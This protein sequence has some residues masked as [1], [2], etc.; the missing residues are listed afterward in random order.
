MGQFRFID[1]NHDQFIVPCILGHD[2]MQGTVA[3]PAKHQS[4]GAGHF[5]GI[6]LDH[7]TRLQNLSHVLFGD[8]S[9]EHALDGVNAEDDLAGIHAGI[10][11][12]PSMPS[13]NS[14]SILVLEDAF[15][16]NSVRRKI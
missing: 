10:I 6:I 12:L 16:Y 13:P 8:S 4:P 11:A 3:A 5:I 7:F 15:V 9:L 1:G 14:N 2:N